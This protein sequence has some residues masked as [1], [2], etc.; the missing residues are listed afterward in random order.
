MHEFI[1]NTV[2][3]DIS[4]LLIF[5]HL[6][7]VVIY[8]LRFQEAVNI[9]RSKDSFKLNFW[10][11]SFSGYFQP[12]IISKCENFQ[13][14]ATGTS[15]MSY[16]FLHSV[17]FTSHLYVPHLMM[18]PVSMQCTGISSSL[19]TQQSEPRIQVQYW[20]GG[21]GGG[22]HHSIVGLC[23]SVFLSLPCFFPFY[24]SIPNLKWTFFW[25]LFPLLSMISYH[26]VTSDLWE[27]FLMFGGYLLFIFAWNLLLL[28]SPLLH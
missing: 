9:H 8:Y 15:Y 5:V 12:R 4:T 21:Q 13:N 1:C 25:N 10:V 7:F 11:F 16:S 28:M 6:I 20:F 2:T 17:F 27:N 26:P 14:Y 22:C 3:P 23:S 24:M 18:W 19:C